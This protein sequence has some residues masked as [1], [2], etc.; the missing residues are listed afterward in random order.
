MDLMGSGGFGGEVQEEK[1]EA[2]TVLAINPPYTP[3]T[4]ELKELEAIKLG[5]LVMEKRHSGK[6]LRVRRREAV[7]ELKGRSWT[8]V[9]DLEG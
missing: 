7:V 4:A 9:E 8:V 1:S 5:D 6:K 3:S 2:I